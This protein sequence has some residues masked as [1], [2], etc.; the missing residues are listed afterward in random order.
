MALY[1][2]KQ[3]VN[4]IQTFCEKETSF[5]VEIIER[6]YPMRLR[7]TPKPQMSLFDVPDQEEGGNITI[8]VGVSTTVTSTLK[9]N[10]DA[11]TLSK[12]IKMSE[13]VGETYLHAFRE[14]IENRL[15]SVFKKISDECVDV[16]WELCV[17]GV[18]VALFNRKLYNDS[19]EEATNH[20]LE[21]IKK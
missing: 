13:S 21:D 7:F 3:A 17:K 20:I 1:D 12:L 6:E 5:E 16:M 9:F 11:K 18:E 10:I 4:D 15:H 8:T 14:C 19:V 2:Y